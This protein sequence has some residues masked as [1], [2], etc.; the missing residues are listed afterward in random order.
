MEITIKIE[1]T[2]LSETLQKVT[3]NQD[4]VSLPNV[5]N[6][7]VEQPIENT[8][9][10][11]EDV[12]AAP[13]IFQTDASLEEDFFDENFSE[14]NNG[15]FFP[16]QSSSELEEEFTNVGQANIMNVQGLN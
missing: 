13:E 7:F 14:E 10:E 8:E 15:S 6:G 5:D 1:G 11:Y 2:N 16:N 3:V 4:T 9:V 12:G